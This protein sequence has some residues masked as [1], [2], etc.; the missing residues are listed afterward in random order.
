[1]ISKSNLRMS[2]SRIKLDMDILKNNLINIKE[3]ISQLNEN[4]NYLFS[5]MTKQNKEYNYEIK[6]MR[7][8][9]DML[10]KQILFEK[11]LKN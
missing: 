6:K 4:Q 11:T 5:E 3:H 1:M 9:I 8:K 2:F 7:D 10:E